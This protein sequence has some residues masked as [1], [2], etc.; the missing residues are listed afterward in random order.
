MEKWSL[1]SNKIQKWHISDPSWG[2]ATHHIAAILYDTSLFGRARSNGISI[3]P[4]C[5]LLNPS[6][7]V[8]QLLVNLETQK[9]DTFIIQVF[10]C[11]LKC[12]AILQDNNLFILV[13]YGWNYRVQFLQQDTMIF[14]N[15]T[16][17]QV[18]VINLC[19]FCL[20]VISVKCIFITLWW[21]TEGEKRISQSWVLAVQKTKGKIGSR[22]HAIPKPRRYWH[23]FTSYLG[24]THW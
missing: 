20:R 22:L 2:I 11:L 8:D 10:S 7:K 17:V 16:F 6:V 21:V 3:W 15:L 9:E 13:K 1:D 5:F 19:W 12:K 4:F 23:V 24:L 18:V 14:T